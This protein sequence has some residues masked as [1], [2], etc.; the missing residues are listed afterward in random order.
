MLPLLIADSPNATVA[1]HGA[2]RIDAAQFVGAVNGLLGQWPATRYAVN[3][4]ENRYYFLLAFAAACLREQITL[5]PPNQTAATLREL[6]SD[7]PD[8]YV[9]DDAAMER[10]LDGLA[11]EPAAKLPTWQIETDKVVALTFTSGST[12]KPQVHPKTWGTLARNAQ[13]AVEEVLGGAG[14]HI[15]ATVPAQHVYGLETSAISAL[16]ARCAV[17]DGKPFFP[18]DVRAALEVLPEPRTLVTTPTHLRAL[19]ESNTELPALRRVVSATAPLTLDLAERIEQTWHTS[20]YEI[21]GCTEAGIMANRRTIEQQP[22]RTFSGGTMRPVHSN[23]GGDLAEYSAPQLPA[24]VPVQD[25]IESLSPST[26]TLSGRAADMIK[27]AGKRTSLQALTQAL[28]NIE[29]VRDAVVFV[30][31]ADARPVALAVAPNVTSQT[32]LQALSE[33]VD[34]V[35]LPRPLILLDALPRNAVG[36]LPHAA[37]LQI[38]R[39]HRRSAS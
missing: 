32:I 33:R 7:Y 14:T 23:D 3:L 24:P 28:L 2:R 30:P 35:F 1:M 18:Q 11:I 6:Q 31:E 5:L 12:G 38:W 20:V 8:Q 26:F 16:S 17:F 9:L 22:W 15:V 34:A 19:I 27:V 36:K 25:M 37:L 13:L 29:G 39:E 4:C 10:L 21:Y